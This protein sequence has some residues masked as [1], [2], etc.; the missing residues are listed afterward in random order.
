MVPPDGAQSLDGGLVAET[1]P[2]VVQGKKMVRSGLRP[3]GL[4]DDVN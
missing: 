1:T 4:L 3:W 2:E